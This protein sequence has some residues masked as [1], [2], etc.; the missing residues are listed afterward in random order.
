MRNI[1]AID[2]SKSGKKF[3][4]KTLSTFANVRIQF[5]HINV[6]KWIRNVNI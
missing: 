4:K 3:L 1:D 5:D 2:V 6:H